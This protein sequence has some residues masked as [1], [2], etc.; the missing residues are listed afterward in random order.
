MLIV[1]V[2]NMATAL[3]VLILE[4][5]RMVGLLMAL[6]A[7]NSLIQK[8]FLYNGVVIMTRGLIF[9]NLIGLVFYFAQ[10]YLGLIR[11]DPKT[12]FVSEAP[13]SLSFSEVIFL[14]LIFL[15]IST[16]LLWIPSK[17]ILKINPSK[18]LRIR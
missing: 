10:K 8:I 17:I 4:R 5:S 11:L 6:G 13:V 9:G 1:G 14:N 7:R 15:F 12:Y 2:I 16:I 3:L 18:V